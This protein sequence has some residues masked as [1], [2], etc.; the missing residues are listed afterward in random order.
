MVVSQLGDLSSLKWTTS[1]QHLESDHDYDVYYCGLNFKDVMLASGKLPSSAFD[2][3]LEI[4]IG[5]EFSGIST[6]GQRVMGY[7]GLNQKTKI[8]LKSCSRHHIWEIPEEWSLAEAAT[9]PVVYMTAILALVIRGQIKTGHRVLI[10]SG[11]G[12]GGHVDNRDCSG[13]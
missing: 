5:G 8:K 7:L 2:E 10:H 6:S 1:P 12:G 13:F 3:R 9:V 11:S 4:P